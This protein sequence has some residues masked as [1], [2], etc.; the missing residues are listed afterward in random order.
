MK[1]A[2]KGTII[3]ASALVLDVA[4]PLAATCSQFPFW[5]EKSSAATV[6]GL[7]IVFAILSA[8]PFIK[9]IKDYFKSPSAWSLW[10][11]LAAVTLAVRHVIEQMTLIA[12]VGAAANLAGAALHKWGEQV[13]E[14]PDKIVEIITEEERT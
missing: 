6:S 3:K 4:A 11:V 9:Q 14:K 1:N 12:L 13:A 8:I 7:F 10:L 2:T 5:V